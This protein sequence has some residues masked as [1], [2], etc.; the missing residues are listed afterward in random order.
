MRRSRPTALTL[1]FVALV[2]LASFAPA[3]A[4]VGRE[5]PGSVPG[6]DPAD[7]DLS[8]DPRQD[9]YRF[10]NGGW[11]DR[12]ELPADEASYG[13]YPNELQDRNTALL[14]ELLTELATGTA[15]R[16]DSDEWKAVRFFQQGTNA[17][18]R[19]AA[20][21]EPIRPL[22]DEIDAIPDLAGFHEY[23]QGATF[24]GIVGG[25]LPIS[26][27]ADQKDS[28]V[29]TLY[30]AGPSLGLPVRDYYLEN[31][32]ANEPIRAAYRETSA[33]LLG[34]L[35]YDPDR[36]RDAAEAVYDLERRLAEPTLTRE[37][38]QDR[39][40]SYNPTAVADLAAR[41]PLMDWPGY[42]QTLG[43]I[44]METVIV[45][46]PGYLD[47]LPAIVAATPVETLKDYLRLRLVWNLSSSLSLAIEE[48]A[49]DFH[50]RVLG[51]VEEMRPIDERALELVNG[52]M[53]EAV[54]KIYVAEAFPPEAKAQVEELVADVKVAFQHRLEANTWMSPATK[55]K[56]LEKL[57]ALEVKVGYPDVWRS[58]EAVELGESFA[59]TTLNALNVEL[60]R[61]LAQAGRPVNPDEWFTPPQTVS[62]YYTAVFNEIL[63]P[64][65]ILQPPFFDYRA[66]PASNYG[67]IG[68]VIGH[69]ITHGFDLQGSQ[70][71]AQGNL[72]NWWT[73]QDNERFQA[74]NDRVV[75]QFGAIE[76]LPGV[77]LNGQITVT[78][79]VADMGGVQV[80]YDALQRR[81][82][83]DGASLPPP[84][85]TETAAGSN[86]TPEQRFF[87]AVATV[88][89]QETRDEALRTQVQAEFHS[90]ARVR[91]IQ[92]IRNMDAFHEAFGIE[93]GDAMYLPPEE[94]IVVW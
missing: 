19:D 76:A 2:W 85:G 56:A 72:A 47:A 58:Y 16:P 14:T 87:V 37:Q 5:Q 39:S 22:L 11:L 23:L 90:P 81:L 83:S 48:T 31:D 91:A 41:Y 55:A 18:A 82:A 43:L 21:I 27:S 94:R 89:R 38:R 88:W 34:H 8:A 32:E 92:P 42:L 49:F 64:A 1:L 12:T 62:A 30:L 6:I 60:R 25:L 40:L 9:F 24:D 93:P 45:T 71:D 79:N 10:A 28:R 54:G 36:A 51:G 67:A 59:E 61:N 63:L 44:G 33:E 7:M 15:V 70:F 66:D 77:F 80:A 74:L 75:A 57:A 13:T 78:E 65:G 29:N 53:G 20:G 73:P 17:A 69:E 26:V 52:L 35:G 4:Q 84:P 68:L 3:L 86:L 50:G 46:E